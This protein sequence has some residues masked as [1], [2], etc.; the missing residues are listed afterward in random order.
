MTL[1]IKDFYLNTDMP[2]YEYMRT[3]VG[4]IPAKIMKLYNLE[5]L[6]HHGA[7]CVEMRKGMCGHPV[8]GRLTNDKLVQI[9]QKHDFVQSDLIP[10]LFKHKTRPLCFSLV[11][12]DFGVSYVGKEHANFLIQV[13]QDSGYT[14]THDWTGS[15]FCGITLNW[16]YANGTEDMYMPGYVEKALKRFAHSPPTKQEDSLH[17]ADPII[18]GQKKQCAKDHDPSNPLDEKGIKRLQEIVGVLLY[19]ARAI[20]YTMLPALGSLAAAQSKATET[21]AKACTKL[22][23][24]AATHPDAVVRYHKSRMILQIHSDT[25]YL[26]ETEARSRAG[27]FFYLGDNMDKSSPDAPPPTLNGAIHINS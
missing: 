24:Y 9:L 5:P 27:G 6:A 3:P 26:S 17:H 20:D 18:Y 16:D 15:I 14:I 22:L 23:N 8:S 7:V 2:H 25:S 4:S 19:Y 12:D 10:G 11:V 1:D 21:T 13:L